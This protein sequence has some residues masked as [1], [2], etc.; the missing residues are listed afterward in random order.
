MPN[1]HAKPIAEVVSEAEKL[2]AQRQDVE[3]LRSAFELLRTA[4][5]PEKRD[6]E[7]EWRFAK[8][9][10]FLA[11][12]LENIKEKEEIFERGRDAGRIALRIEPNKPDGHFWY[13]ANLGELA[14]ISP[15]TVGIRSV[16]DIQESMNRVI[17]LDPAYQ[18]ATAFDALAQ[19]EMATR[20]YRGKA[21]KAIEYLER[22]IAIN[23]ANAY[24]RANLA[25]AYLAVKRDADA[26]K[27]IEAVL[28]MK[29]DADYPLEHNEA[30]E[31][32]KRLL[33]R[34]F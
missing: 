31:K 4:R 26:R 29:V 14:K 33:A 9:S 32:A 25:E 5:N 19:V 12:R 8:F 27:Q 30:V 34:N 13:G 24:V 2:F 20:A 10:Y 16:D 15:V 22:S 17:E 7:V 3:K 1:S 6:F 18:G 21:E 28:R 23:P 11:K